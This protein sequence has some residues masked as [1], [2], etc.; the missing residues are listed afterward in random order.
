MERPD[1]E[2]MAELKREMDAH[3]AVH[4]ALLAD[5]DYLLGDQFSAADCAAFPFLKY[6]LKPRAKVSSRRTE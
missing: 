2:Q 5:R 1:E 4:Q 3:L 6:P